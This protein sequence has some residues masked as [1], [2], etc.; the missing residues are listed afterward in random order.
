[1]AENNPYS[2][3][4]LGIS[5]ESSSVV[6]NPYSSEAL[7]QPAP[8]AVKQSMYVGVQKNPDEFAK[9]VNIA[10]QMKIPSD[11]VESDYGA[12]KQKLDLDK[13][14]PY[15]L[16][17][18]FPR[19]ASW[20][21]NPDNAGIAHDDLV[22]LKRMESAIEGYSFTSDLFA[23]LNSGIASLGKQFFQ[24]PA[25]IVQTA[26]LGPYNAAL[27]LQGEIT[28]RPD[29]YD[30]Y[31][32]QL[33][34]DDWLIDNPVSRYFDRRSKE[35]AD[36]TTEK[37]ISPQEIYDAADGGD[38]K[39]AGRQLAYLAAQNLPIIIGTTAGAL[40]GYGT[41]V[42]AGAA[43]VSGS[44]ANIQGLEAGVDPVA[45]AANTL[46]NA[47]IEYLGEKIFSVLPIEALVAKYGKTASN[48]IF[49]TAV[50]ILTQGASEFAGEG[51]TQIGQSGTG[52]LTGV[53]PDALKTIGPDTLV[54]AI[55]GFASGTSLSA[56]GAIV[57]GLQSSDRKIDRQ[58]QTKNTV[59]TYTEIGDAAKESKLRER[60]PQKLENYVETQTKDT[61]NESIYIS[62][63]AFETY[64]QDNTVD[65]LTK[66]DALEAYDTAKETGTDVKIP[67][68]KWTARLSEEEYNGLKDDIKFQ[69]DQLS[70]KETKKLGEEVQ[71]VS[72][73]SVVN[74]EMSA[75][76]ESVAQVKQIVKDQLIASGVKEVVA[77][78][79]AT[80]DAERVR[81]R[82][83]L[84][85]VT[86]LEQYNSRNLTI[87]PGTKAESTPG[88]ESYNQDAFDDTRVAI[89]TQLQVTNA[90]PDRITKVSIPADESLVGMDEKGLRKSSL[91][92]AKSSTQ[93]LV[94]NKHTGS[95]ISISKDGL[96]KSANLAVRPEQALALK[97]VS[98][99]LENAIYLRSE[100]DRNKP[101]SKTTF[102]YYY[103]PYESG[104]KEYVAKMVVKRGRKDNRFY[105]LHVMEV[106]GRVGQA[107]PGAVA[108]IMLEGADPVQGS[109]SKAELFA[110][111]NEARQTTPLYQQ[112]SDI[113]GQIQISR[114]R[115]VISLFKGQNPSTFL[116]EVG[117]LYLDEIKEDTEA[118]KAREPSTLTA[119][120][121]RFLED[122]NSVLEF[123][124][125][126]SFDQIGE[127]EQEKWARTFEEYL[128]EGKAP[129]KKLKKAFQSFK[130][131]LTKIYRQ[132]VG[133]SEI[134]PE[135]RQ[136]FDR[137]L[138]SEEEIA[139]AQSEQNQSPIFTTQEASG[140]NDKEWED[141]LQAA[142]EAKQYAEDTITNEVMEDLR[143]LQRAEYKEKRAEVEESIR[144]DLENQPVYIARAAIKSGEISIS[145]DAA[146][147]IY[148]KDAIKEVGRGILSDNGELTPDAA[149]ELL[150]FS[151]G[152]A[153]LKELTETPKLEE[154]VKDLADQMMKELY[155][156]LF[157]TPKMSEE[158]MKAIHNDAR[159]RMLRLELEYITRK[160]MPVFRNLVRRIGRRV[161]SEE[162][163]RQ[164]AQEIVGKQEIK[165]I[166]PYVY[167]L[168]ERKAAKSA[169]EFLAKGDI[170]SAFEAKRKELLNHELFRAAT[171][172]KEKSDKIVKYMR[173]FLKDSTRGRIGLA[174]FTY[175]DQIDSIMERFEFKKSTSF[176]E[177]EKRKSIAEFIKYTI[178]EDGVEPSL[179][180]EVMQD[181]FR[182]S[183]KELTF[184]ELE[185][186]YDSVQNIE[187]L[188]RLKNKLL[189]NK[190]YRD[191]AEAVGLA[192]ASIEENAKG[193]KKPRPPET[194]LPGEEL[195]RIGAGF[196]ADHRKFASFISEMDG[197]NEGGILWDLFTRPMNEAGDKEA[198]KN[199]EAT[200]ALTDIFS[201]YSRKDIKNFYIKQDIPELGTSL[202]KAGL[203]SI[204][205]NQG[206]MDNKQKLANGRGWTQNQ[207]DKALDRLDERDWKF[208]QN[209]WDY[210]NT[211]WP[212]T[213][214]LSKRVNGIA[215]GKV[216]A[217]SVKTKYGTFP[218]GY[219]PLKYDDRS[220]PK[221][222]ANSA[223]EAA[224]AAMRGGAVRS[225]TKQGFR[226]ARVENVTEPV[227]LDLGVIFEHVAEVIHDQTHYEFLI[228]ANK[229]LRNK[230]LQTAILDQYGDI[231][232]GQ[233]RDALNS[234][235]AG[236]VPA[237]TSAEKA[238]NYLRQG[239]TI[240]GLGWNLTTTLFQPLGLTQSMVKIGPKWVARGLKHWMGDAYR[241]ENT[242]KL[243]YEK[244]DFMRLRGETMQREISEIRNKVQSKSGF[245]GDI[246]DSYFY[247]IGKAQMIA[248]IPTWLGAYEKY[249]E[250]FPNDEAKVIALADQAVIDSQ[251]GG[252][253]KDLANIQ[254][255]SPLFKIWTNFYSFMNV[256]YNLTV[257]AFKR[258][259]RK[260]P[261]SVGRLAAD[262]T[263]LYTVPLVLM[264]LLRG[265]LKGSLDDDEYWEKF[266]SELPAAQATDILGNFVYVRDIAQAI[267]GYRG[268]EGPAGT[269]FFAKAGNL[270]KQVNQGEPDAAFWKSLNQVG[271]IL[272]H[273][274]AG[275]V[276]RFARGVDALNS[277]ET[278]NPGVLITGPKGKK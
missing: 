115:K 60:S 105:S 234:I 37:T 251:G 257:E 80:L 108:T 195:Y 110:A 66:L 86:P 135:I 220:S 170:D 163:V 177:I 92:A 133:G 124:G 255:G 54:S 176:A 84:M 157:D 166:K 247:F 196:L 158:A 85:G 198:V 243:I 219:F 22:P 254:K 118:L 5:P 20:L 12:F 211:Y 236:D 191:F 99:L 47:G 68:S 205:L 41:P 277:G 152:D 107:S 207:V 40:A 111:V 274:P 8:S 103:A 30:P 258:T 10:D 179:S 7:G 181:A 72:N 42:A 14:D 23:N 131:W 56:P 146:I 87:Q 34:K 35:Y 222:Y 13:L 24:A 38:Y 186:I 62:P 28:G 109:V 1:M 266:I 208:V 272:F 45:Q 25:A 183:Y 116:H 161:P 43:V 61:A 76:E 114:A 264:T 97:N 88:A 180:P 252:Q 168:A 120:Q 232:Y 171:S 137:L 268:Y 125:V 122:S 52:Y 194:R 3:E 245:L 113:L 4:A 82:A 126:E 248:D 141:Y 270:A 127:K 71:A 96:K 256:R 237:R 173:G 89:E 223:K 233:L 151:S 167:E 100:S 138:A 213:E 197:F 44:Q 193:K 83:R 169:A 36:L 231:V 102:D 199:A 225:T 261:T 132:A 31:K 49:K 93:S 271:G 33:S 79:Q 209:V 123:L 9:V 273:Y 63:E 11:L 67:T 112:D 104:G 51:L 117:H 90:I 18:S 143:K 29:L 203:L 227:R 184:N 178:E 238:F 156:D 212:E 259:N 162:A 267:Q 46:G 242:T 187:H 185:G 78:K 228:D 119:D 15:T 239:S 53:E 19:M 139:L 192:V 77:E 32:L 150:G 128:R 229:L 206:T 189:A 269:S 91:D 106:G 182:K 214:A 55:L 94:V 250:K 165:D 147:E 57:T 101:T 190:N 216:P 136:I 202:T 230:A 149:A 204:A 210:I 244:S 98:T 159:A 16:Q 153:L 129:S 235:A 218:G 2:S 21:E 145:R 217:S 70:V 201:A 224:D 148:G 50:D 48:S 278:K 188:A 39:T 59:D 249:T 246:E 58:R 6:N 164:Q 140:M 172:A 240:A 155:P 175:L 221:A 134:S 260:S 26:V 65:T 69:P 121:S 144:G 75:E 74:D 275:Q 73:E 17:K 95:D 263:I 215:P 276:E 226:K 81:N 262:L 154:K 265:A 253:I 27:G 174:G 142:A 130:A 160:E 64:F 200:K 241:M